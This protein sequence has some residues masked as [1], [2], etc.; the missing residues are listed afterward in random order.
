MDSTNMMENAKKLVETARASGATIIHAPIRFADGYHEITDHPY[1]I[2]AGVVDNKAFV[3]DTWGAD[4]RR[5]PRAAGG[6]HRDRG[7][8]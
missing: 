5:R 2:L 8:A 7:Q 3:K 4:I 1:G 6:R